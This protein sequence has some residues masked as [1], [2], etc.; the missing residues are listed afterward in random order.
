LQKA[1]ATSPRDYIRKF[2]FDTVTFSVPYLAYLI[3]QFGADTLMA[4]TDGQQQL[5]GASLETF[6]DKACGGDK[7]MAEKL[8]W[9][10]A[11]RFFGLKNVT[12]QSLA[13]E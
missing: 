4:G 11:A 1:V 3:E 12:G 6:I 2:Y 9:R 7:Q 13:A 8:L 10:N 5:S